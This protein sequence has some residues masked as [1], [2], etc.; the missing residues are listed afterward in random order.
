MWLTNTFQW[1]MLWTGKGSKQG[2]DSKGKG[3]K[4]DKGEESKAPA[5]VSTEVCMFAI[6]ECSAQYAHG[7]L[8][9]HA[10][11]KFKPDLS[12]T[13]YFQLWV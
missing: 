10:G 6:I 5:I 13:F 12:L 1:L 11:T 3:K 8:L 4:K 7:N 9:L 2:K